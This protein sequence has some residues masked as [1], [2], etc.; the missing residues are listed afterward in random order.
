MSQ[1]SNL[2]SQ[3]LQNIVCRLPF[4]NAFR[5]IYATGTKR[6]VQMSSVLLHDVSVYD[7]DDFQCI[8]WLRNG[9]DT[10]AYHSIASLRVKM[11]SDQPLDFLII[12]TNLTLFHTAARYSCADT[13]LNLGNIKIHD[14]RLLETSAAKTVHTLT[15]TASGSAA[16]V[17]V[18][19][20]QVENLSVKYIH[21]HTSLQARHQWPNLKRLKLQMSFSD[22]RLDCGQKYY[23]ADSNICPSL[24]R[25]SIKYL[26]LIKPVEAF[27]RLP[28][29]A[30][31]G[32]LS[33][34]F[35]RAEPYVSFFAQNCCKYLV[36][37]R[38]LKAECWP[39]DPAL[40]IASLPPNLT[41]L[42]LRGMK[43]TTVEFFRLKHVI[44]GINEY[45]QNQ[46]GT[47]WELKTAMEVDRVSLDK[48]LSRSTLLQD[49]FLKRSSN[50]NKHVSKEF[51][52]RLYDCN[53]HDIAGLLYSVLG[54]DCDWWRDL[55]QKEYRERLESLHV[56][57]CDTQILLVL[58]QCIRALY[59]D[60]NKSR[61]VV[62]QIMF[63][64]MNDNRDRFDKTLW[65]RLLLMIKWMETNRGKIYGRMINVGRQVPRLGG[66]VAKSFGVVLCSPNVMTTD[67]CEQL[68]RLA[69]NP[70]LAKSCCEGI[71]S[72]AWF[73]HYPVWRN[74]SMTQRAFQNI[75]GIKLL[76]SRWSR[77]VTILNSKDG[78]LCVCV[79][80]GALE[81]KQSTKKV[82]A[83]LP[84]ERHHVQAAIATL[85]QQIQK[86]VNED[87]M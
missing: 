80:S 41:S 72:S 46:D 12:P 65:T 15:L 50:H 23:S 62:L 45:I 48:L 81:C 51:V 77:E 35:A 16:F 64:W 43:N 82:T 25:L 3:A 13:E 31:L 53:R 5:L 83:Y 47:W 57:R 79:Y 1:L 28:K 86:V 33:L 76:L 63:D 67:R 49:A 40:H 4:K 14:L 10:Q 74:V 8:V 37:L 24:E 56:E 42:H 6:F 55:S 73:D 75:T 18:Q 60:S 66:N 85:V 58:R 59:A 26:E 68:Y 52:Q 29:I 19:L 11:W 2:D 84:T 71:T 44:T 36:N 69:N 30:N 54:V 61:I 70:T 87:K 27:L 78:T 32:R 17:G 9:G 7:H 38:Q 39:E 21:W 34:S 20:P 22:T